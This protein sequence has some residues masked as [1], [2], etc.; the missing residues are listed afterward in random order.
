MVNPRSPY[1]IIYSVPVMD[2]FSIREIKVMLE[3]GKIPGKNGQETWTMGK[4]RHILDD[5]KYTGGVL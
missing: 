4:I 1:I 5:E 2:G 3:D